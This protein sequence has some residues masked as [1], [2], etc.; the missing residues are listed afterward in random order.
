M[1][2]SNIS[3]SPACVNTNTGKKDHPYCSEERKLCV[4]V[5]KAGTF[6]YFRRQ[7]PCELFTTKRHHSK[8]FSAVYTFFKD[9]VPQIW[10]PWMCKQVPVATAEAAGAFK[11]LRQDRRIKACL[12]LYR[13]K[14]NLPITVKECSEWLTY[15]LSGTPSRTTRPRWSQA[16]F[17]WWSWQ[18]ISLGWTLPFIRCVSKEFLIGS[19]LASI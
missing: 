16:R 6:L 9:P 1:C 17:I 12:D 15:C 18:F 7:H 3:I 13:Q 11:A 10:T 8:P 4:T 19:R 14:I 2:Q 5:Y